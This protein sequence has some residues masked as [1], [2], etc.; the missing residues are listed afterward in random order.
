MAAQ[1]E[2]YRSLLSVASREQE[3][4]VAG[5]VERLTALVEQKEELLDHLHALETE[6]MTALVAIQMATGIRAETATISEVAARLPAGTAE[7]LQ[8]AARELRAEALALEEAHA[9]NGRLLENSRA[10]VDRWVHYLRMVLA[11]SIYTP[12][13]NDN[14]ATP[15]GRALDRSA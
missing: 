6:R 14:R 12:D 8:R 3:S 9:A 4:I 13:G 7:A 5:D 15:G 1:R 2:L 11:G 10:L